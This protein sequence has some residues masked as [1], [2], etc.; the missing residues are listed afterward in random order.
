MH[1]VDYIDFEG[2]LCGG[3]LTLLAQAANLLDTVIGCTVNLDHVHT[4]AIHNGLTGL[5]FIVGRRTRTAF[6]IESL[7]EKTRGTGLTRTA[8]PH[9]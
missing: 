4:R 7:S 9:K 2:T 5:R 1:F 3:E 8:W 6:S